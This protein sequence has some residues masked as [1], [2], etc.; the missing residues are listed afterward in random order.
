[1]TLV[2]EAVIGKKG[3]ILPKKNLRQISGLLPGDKVVIEAYPNKL[4]V[5]KLLSVDELFQLPKIATG[6]P[7]AIEADL[8]EENRL[9]EE[10]TVK[11]LKRKVGE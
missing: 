11:K 4:I 1:M 8:H 5:R 7:E 2:D 10:M 3:E 6:T 9:Q